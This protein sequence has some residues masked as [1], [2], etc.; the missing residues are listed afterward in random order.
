M[1]MSFLRWVS[2]LMD[3]YTEDY[4]DCGERPSR[5]ELYLAI[6][7]ILRTQSTC[8]RGK[9]GAL[10]VA[11]RRIIATGYNGAPPGMRH[12]LEVGCDVD[13]D[14]PSG[15]C[16]R[17]I[18]AES[19]LLAFAARHAGGAGGST[20]YCTHGPCLK[21]AQLIISAGVERVVFQM[22]YRLPSGV[23]LLDAANVTIKQVP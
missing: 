19:N 10:L 18:H 13:S 14:D 16:R 17:A 2:S 11:D 7:Q 8:E 4:E 21:C 23:E 20:L 9:V 3:G 1:P 6:C 22:P 12:C 5:E 15:G